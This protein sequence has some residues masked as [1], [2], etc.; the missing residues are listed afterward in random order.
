VTDQDQTQQPKWYIGLLPLQ[1]WYSPLLRLRYRAA[2]ARLC[3]A[4]NVIHEGIFFTPPSE[5]VQAIAHKIEVEREPP[6]DGVVYFED[7]ER[8]DAVE[9][10][11]RKYGRSAVVNLP[12]SEENPCSTI[13]VTVK[14]FLDLFECESF[15]E[16]AIIFRDS[17]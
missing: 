3:R 14:M 5:A 10:S 11:V 15:D 13:D 7:S 16:I 2:V 9:G 12:E 1:V 4:T 6:P 17:R 8:K